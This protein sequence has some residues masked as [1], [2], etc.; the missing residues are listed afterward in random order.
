MWGKQGLEETREQLGFYCDRS[1]PGSVLPSA[2]RQD[3]QPQA[4]SWDENMLFLTL[5]HRHVGDV[6]RCG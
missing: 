4:S 2:R 5:L 6:Q 1:F 3:L